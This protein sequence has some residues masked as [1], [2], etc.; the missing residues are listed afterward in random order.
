MLDLGRHHLEA[1]LMF[2][3]AR[4]ST[5]EDNDR[6]MR[7]VALAKRIGEV[8]DKEYPGHYFRTEVDSKG[9][10]VQIKHPLMP[11]HLFYVIKLKKLASD[12]G[13][14]LVKRAA[15]ELLE[16]VNQRR[17]RRNEADWHDARQKHWR[18]MN[19]L[20]TERNWMTGETRY[21]LPDE[22]K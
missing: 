9:G 1:C 17:G 4:P 19:G 11:P 18:S 7:D 13:F 16:R 21:R 6:A 20:L 12:P 14:T 3:Q 22:W 5:A 2:W 8:I 15:G 10:V